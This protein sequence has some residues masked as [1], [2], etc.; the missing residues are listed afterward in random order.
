MIYL[1]LIYELTVSKVIDK[2]LMIKPTGD[3]AIYSGFFMSEICGVSL[4]NN[5]CIINKFLI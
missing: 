1:H 2:Q 5:F 4:V 3:A